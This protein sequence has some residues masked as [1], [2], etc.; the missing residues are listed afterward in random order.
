MMDKIK[1]LMIKITKTILQKI[2]RIFGRELSEGFW[3]V[4]VQF[5]GFAVVGVVNFL[6]NYVTYALFLY[7]HCNYHVANIAAFIVSVFNSFY[8]NNKY[9]FKQDNDGQ[10]SWWKTLLKT[11]VSYAF[12]GLFLTELLLYIEI[13][14][15]GL[16]E[17][18]GPAI[19][20]FITT[21]INFVMNKFWAFRGNQ[22]EE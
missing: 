5:I 14:I 2:F 9:V 12:S 11:Y 19:N 8:W 1:N 16:P 17:I 20:L 15:M 13:N 22:S 21:P 6:V 7:L 18:A 4:C 3:N 10:R